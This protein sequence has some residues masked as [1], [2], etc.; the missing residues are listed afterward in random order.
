MNNSELHSIRLIFADDAKGGITVIGAAAWNTQ[1]EQQSAWNAVQKLNGEHDTSFFAELLDPQD[2]VL[3]DIPVTAE[4][5]ERLMG[6]PIQALI[7]EGR[8]KSCYT[9]D[10]FLTK[11]PDLQTTFKHLASKTSA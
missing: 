1:L 5:C 3:E 4:T 7:E 8:A 2:E 11:Y 10:D 6:K 9:V